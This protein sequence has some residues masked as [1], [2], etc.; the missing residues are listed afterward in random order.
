[1]TNFYMNK[2]FFDACK[3]SKEAKKL[4]YSTAV[5]SGKLQFQIVKYR[6]NGTSEVTPVTDFLTFEE[7]KEILEAS[8]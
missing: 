2:E 8:K 5:K 6:S 1:M 3:I 7:A 4:G